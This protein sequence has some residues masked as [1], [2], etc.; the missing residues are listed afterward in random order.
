MN[1]R[2]RACRVLARIAALALLSGC[3]SN[4]VTT[5]LKA[6]KQKDAVLPA[7]AVVQGQ[8]KGR[9]FEVGRVAFDPREAEDKQGP[10]IPASAYVELL[11]A[12]LEKAFAR[13][14]LGTGSVPA[15]PVNV[16]IERVTLKPANFLI[17]SAPSTLRI[18]VTIATATGQ[19]VM[20]GQFEASFP[21]PVTTIYASGFVIPVALPAKDW[22]Y[23]AL[24][25][26]F[27]A[28]AV[29]VTETVLGLQAGKT[30]DEI[31]IYPHDI[32]A[33]ALISPDSF[34]KSSPFGMTQMSSEEIGRVIREAR[35][36][37]G[38]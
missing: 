21:P 24:A 5:L 8:L 27:P 19:D 25:R 14:G 26:M 9:A 28:A 37:E 18:Q 23:V 16:T 32:D 33:G 4:N 35:A 7:A 30:L 13:A 2:T 36:R 11:R 12:Q 38:Q 1:G 29:V 20:R 31:K 15:Y 6:S 3:A 10:D 17:I 34:L 22:E